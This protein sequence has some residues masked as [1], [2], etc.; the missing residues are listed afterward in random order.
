MAKLSAHQRQSLP[1]SD[2]ALPGKGKG[3]KGAG[4]GSYPIPDESHAR[5]ALARSANKSPEVKAR[6]RAKVHAKYP[7]IGKAGG[8]HVI[9]GEGEAPKH[10]A[11]KKRRA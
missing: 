2:F 5:N 1:K 6:V 9:E 8:G 7:G 10:G 11:H 3:P 4:S